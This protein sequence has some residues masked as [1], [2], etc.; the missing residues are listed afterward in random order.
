MQRRFIFLNTIISNNGIKY[1]TNKNRYNLTKDLLEYDKE[2]KNFQI[3]IGDYAIKN[4]LF[5]IYKSNELSFKVTSEMVKKSLYQTLNQTLNINLISNIFKGL[6]NI[7][8]KE[9]EVN[10]TLIANSLPNIELVKDY[11]EPDD[12]PITLEHLP[13]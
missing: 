5:T 11:I 13:H 1:F 9:K 3:I 6:E 12:L 10:I 2:G 7:Y 4:D 8:D